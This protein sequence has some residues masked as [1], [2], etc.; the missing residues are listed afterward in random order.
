MVQS[1]ETVDDA[2]IEGSNS[3]DP[4]NPVSE[5]IQ[6][7]HDDSGKRRVHIVRRDDGAFT[8]EEQHFSD[9]PDEQTWIPQTS[10]RS[11]P[12]C[13]THYKAFC[14]ALER[15]QWDVRSTKEYWDSAGLDLERRLEEQIESVP[16]VHYDKTYEEEDMEV[17]WHIATKR[18]DLTLSFGLSCAPDEATFH[19]FFNDYM[20]MRELLAHQWKVGTNPNAYQELFEECAELVRGILESP[21]LRIVKNLTPG[22][23]LHRYEGGS[24]ISCGGAMGLSLGIKTVYSDWR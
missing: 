10:H 23:R 13:D 19:V 9:H 20:S 15:I 3:S 18:S 12:V 1:P 11:L 17:E 5:I 14:E 16:G 6:T 24:W 4:L 2:I 8:F 7:L 21:K 22:A